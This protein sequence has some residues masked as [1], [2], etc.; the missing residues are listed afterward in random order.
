M[1]DWTNKMRRWAGSSLEPGEELVAATVIHPP[2]TASRR[3]KGALLGGAL[4][5]AVASELRRTEAPP[6]GSIAAGLPSAT[7]HRRTD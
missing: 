1:A 4:G 5:A 3:I 6:K 2:G 7:V